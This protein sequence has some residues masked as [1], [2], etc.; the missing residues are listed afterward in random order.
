MDIVQ[1]QLVGTRSTRQKSAIYEVL[2]DIGRPMTP[3]EICGACQPIVPGLSI[4]TVYRNLRQLQD[5]LSIVA[6]NLP[7]DSARYELAHVGHHHHFQ[8]NSCD[9]VFDIYQCPGD[10]AKLA[11]KGFKVES[12]DLTLYG[13]CS[14]CKAPAR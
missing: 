6:V 11:P 2:R 4:A 9:R 1:K 8:C 13:R 10:F 14:D 5:A 3:Q 12:H 7:N